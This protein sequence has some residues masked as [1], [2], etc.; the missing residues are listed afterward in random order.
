MFSRRRSKTKVDKVED[1]EADGEDL[2]YVP[3]K[4][5]DVF[6]EKL[7]DAKKPTPEEVQPLLEGLIDPGSLPN[8]DV[9]LRA[10]Q[11]SRGTPFQCQAS[12]RNRLPHLCDWCARWQLKTWQRA[13]QDVPSVT[14]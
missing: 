13:T 10:S 11:L 5:L 8:E 12:R 3:K 2:Y 9:M 14:A 4:A 6:K 1:A 7:K